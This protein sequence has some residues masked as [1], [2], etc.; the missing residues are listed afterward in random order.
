MDRTAARLTPRPVV[1]ALALAACLAATGRLVEPAYAQS[2]PLGDSGAVV[3]V[4]E[5]PKPWFAPRF[6]IVG[7]MRDTI[8]QYRDLAGLTYKAYSFSQRDGRYGG[9]YLWT[10]RASADAWFDAAWHARV[11]RERGAKGEVRIFDA[12]VVLDNTAGVAVADQEKAVST[13]VTLPIPAGI[14]RARLVAEFNAQLPTYR[15]VD[16]LLRKYFIVTSD[17]KFGGVYLWRDQAAGDRWFDAKWH[18]RVRT[19]YG[20]D[21]VLEWFDTPILLPTRAASN[22]IAVA[23]PDAA[24]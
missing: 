21:A 20:V 13:L 4:V 12:P 2:P 24:R 16:G 17:G 8:P 23:R 19:T 15:K 5:V 11:E 9:I 18:D 14:D 22:G 10:D 6:V 1:A 7:R 3:A